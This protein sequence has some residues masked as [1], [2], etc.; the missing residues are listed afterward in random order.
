[1]LLTQYSQILA[2][3]GGGVSNYSSI[4]SEGGYKVKSV[5]KEPEFKTLLKGTGKKASKMAT[6]IEKLAEHIEFMV[7][8]ELK[9]FLADI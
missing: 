3:N 4:V 5:K 8:E 1:M 6:K 2:W 9:Q 7:E